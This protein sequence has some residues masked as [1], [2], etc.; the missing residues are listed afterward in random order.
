M[1][2]KEFYKIILLNFFII[3]KKIFVNF[4]LIEEQIKNYS[5]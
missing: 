1:K 5:K 4:I 3:L 2:K